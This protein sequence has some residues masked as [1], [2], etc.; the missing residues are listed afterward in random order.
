M[1]LSEAILLG[2]TV[3]TPKPGRLHFSRENAG[4]APG[5]AVFARGAHSAGQ[6]G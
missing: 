3:V 1:R 6:K 4:C 2:S 5:T